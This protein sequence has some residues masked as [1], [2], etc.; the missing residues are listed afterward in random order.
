MSEDD[1]GATTAIT[2]SVFVALLDF[3]KLFLIYIFFYSVTFNHLW[4]MAKLATF[5]LKIKLKVY[6][7]CKWGSKRRNQF[8][9][10]D[11]VWRLWNIEFFFKKNHFKCQKTTFFHKTRFV[12]IYSIKQVYQYI[13][14]IKVNG[15]CSA[16]VYW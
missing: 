8:I 6:F 1:S 11:K 13:H 4:L 16:K 14:A 2:K 7:C 5:F 9:D 15:F 3:L 12:I 10:C